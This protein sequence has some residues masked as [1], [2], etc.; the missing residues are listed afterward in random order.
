MIKL[1]KKYF[2]EELKALLTDIVSEYLV[3]KVNPHKPNMSNTKLHYYKK[4]TLLY[5]EFELLMEKDKLTYLKK[6]L[7]EEIFSQRI[8][9]A[10]YIF[11][12]DHQYIIDNKKDKEK[13][14]RLISIYNKKIK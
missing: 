1:C 7:R 10:S 6:F 12:T 2:F 13:Y 8:Q 5:K 3:N 4:I 14:Y 11:K 9:K